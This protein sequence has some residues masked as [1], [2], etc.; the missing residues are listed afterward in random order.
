[1]DDVETAMALGAL[2]LDEQDLALC[3]FVDCG[4]HDFGPVLR[5]N[6]DQIRREHGWPETEPA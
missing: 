6:L 4:K 1:V 3:S 2:E 5:R